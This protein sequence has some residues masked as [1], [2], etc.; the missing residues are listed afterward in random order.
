[1]SLRDGALDNEV[2]AK[3]DDPPRLVLTSILVGMVGGVAFL[4]LVISGSLSGPLLTALGLADST[5]SRKRI[6]QQAELAARRRMLD[7]FIHLMTDARFYFVD[8]SL[9]QHHCPML[10]N[11]TAV[12]LETAVQQNKDS[13]HPDRYLTPNLEHVL[14]Y[15]PDSAALRWAIEKSK[16]QMFMESAV[17]EELHTLGTTL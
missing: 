8:F 14:P 6:V 7:D 11:L 13:V 9:V 17:D 2:K 10:R 5:E 15:V 1:M 3:T 16:R 4:T 12:E